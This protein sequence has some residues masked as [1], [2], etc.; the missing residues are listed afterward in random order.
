MRYFIVGYPKM[1]NM[2]YGIY[3]YRIIE[4]KTFEEAQKVG[5]QLSREVIEEFCHP[6][7]EWYSHKDYVEEHNIEKWDNEYIEDYEAIVDSIINEQIEYKIYEV[8]SEVNE[9]AIRLWANSDD[10]VNEFVERYCT[11]DGEW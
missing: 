6:N 11:K 2:Q 3:D 10:D 8:K 5:R 9:E 7:E 1:Y 4:P